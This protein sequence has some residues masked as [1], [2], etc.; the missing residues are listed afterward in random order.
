MEYETFTLLIEYKLMFCCEDGNQLT[1]FM[2]MSLNLF[3]SILHGAQNRWISLQQFFYIL[4]LSFA[5]NPTHLFFSPPPIPPIILLL[6]AACML[7]SGGLLGTITHCHLRCHF[8]STVSTNTETGKSTVMGP[9]CFKQTKRLYMDVVPH[10]L[11]ILQ[12][13]LYEY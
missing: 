7:T 11:W 6:P 5:N 3:N 1:S 12:F 13:I 2:N 10:S 9:V 8:C 4:N